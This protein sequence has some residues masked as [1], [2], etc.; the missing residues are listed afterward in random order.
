MP[1]LKCFFNIIICCRKYFTGLTFIYFVLRLFTLLTFKRSLHSVASWSG[2]ATGQKMYK[3]K[4]PNF[5]KVH[6]KSIR[7]SEELLITTTLKDCKKVWLVET[8]GKKKIIGT[9]ENFCTVLC[10]YSLV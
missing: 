1:T 10:V 7:M 6:W 2:T 5:L 3:K 8:K 9:I 4:K